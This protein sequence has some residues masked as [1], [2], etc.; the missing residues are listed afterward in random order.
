[1]S[2]KMQHP[3]LKQAGRHTPSR[4]SDNTPSDWRMTFIKRETRLIIAFIIVAV[5]LLVVIRLGSEIREDGTSDFDRWVLLSLR[6]SDNTGLPIGPAWLRPVFVDITA[7]GGVTALTLLTISVVGHL[8][9]A[10]KWITAGLIVAATSSGSLIGHILKIGFSRARPTIVP[11]FVE[12]HTLSYP[13]G[14]A[15][16]SAV[17]FLTLGALLARAQTT[18]P[19]RA[20]VV[21]VALLF[22]VLIG[23]SRVYNGVHWPT[24]VIAGWAIGGSWALLWW[25]IALRVQGTR[26]SLDR[27]A[28]R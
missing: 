22:T 28:L 24:D 19:T 6:Q 26:G 17:V 5:A 21:A 18:R 8:L 10:K 7:L 3:V 23:C 9:V 12:I 15:T 2:D 1:M 4:R 27:E 25:A 13:S 20:Y 16:N 11:H 14:H